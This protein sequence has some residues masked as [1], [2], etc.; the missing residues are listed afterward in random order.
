MQAPN[1][2]GPEIVDGR[3]WDGSDFVGGG[4]RFVTKRVVHWFKKQQIGPFIAAPA[5]FDLTGLTDKQRE[6]V[7]R[8]KQLIN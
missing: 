3:E 6:Q 2:R 5:L 4:W 8:A 1:E 7:Q